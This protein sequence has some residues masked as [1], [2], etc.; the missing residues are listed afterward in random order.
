V[1][2]VESANAKLKAIGP[3]AT[4]GARALTVPATRQRHRSR[5]AEAPGRLGGRAAGSVGGHP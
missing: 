5:V 3:K 4:A 1:L 2:Q